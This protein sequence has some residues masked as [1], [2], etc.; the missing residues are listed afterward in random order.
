MKAESSP[1]AAAQEIIDQGFVRVRQ[2]IGSERLEPLRE[3]TEL[4][5]QRARAQT[6]GD[7]NIGW[8][9]HRVPHPGLY[10][11][12]D[13]DTNALFDA[14]L[15]APL[16]AVNCQLMGAE[17]AGLNSASLFT[18]PARKL[19][20]RFQFH[21]DFSP[22]ASLPLCG[23]Q[24]DCQA[25]VPGHLTWNF[26]LYDDASL[27]VVP[28]SNKRS[29][30]PTTAG[31]PPCCWS[32]SQAG[33]CKNCGAI[34]RPSTARLRMPRNPSAVS[35]CIPPPTTVSQCRSSSTSMNSSPA[36]RRGE[37]L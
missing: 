18:E 26:A 5:L 37:A 4:F 6:P 35:P 14:L 28:G 13:G 11:F 36:G 23:L 17:S 21:R 16:L 15:S 30:M 32:A 27:W 9:N 33:K 19:K 7:R 12:I 29:I 20:K 3:T 31:A 24:A 10:D 34:S 2:A 22:T 25:N 8:D 1:V